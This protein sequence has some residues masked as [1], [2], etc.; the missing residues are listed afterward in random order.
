M[1]RSDVE[2]RYRVELMHVMLHIREKTKTAVTF[3]S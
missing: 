1:P 2:L 3:I